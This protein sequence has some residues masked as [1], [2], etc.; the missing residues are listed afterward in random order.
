MPKFPIHF[1]W[2]FGKMVI[3]LPTIVQYTTPPYDE[4]LKDIHRSLIHLK[5]VVVHAGW[6][7]IVFVFV[8]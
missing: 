6:V 3:P 5:I 2:G 4:F 7:A 1:W 8:F